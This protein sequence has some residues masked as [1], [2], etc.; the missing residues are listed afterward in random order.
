MAHDA[1]IF[2]KNHQQ[3]MHLPE[4][5]NDVKGQVLLA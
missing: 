2:M 1:M 3:P 4:N 5:D